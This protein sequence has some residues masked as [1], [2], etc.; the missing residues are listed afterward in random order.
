MKELLDNIQL[1]I[2]ENMY[3]DVEVQMK[4]LEPLFDKSYI[5]CRAN[6]DSIDLRELLKLSQLENQLTKRIL[7]VKPKIESSSNLNESDKTVEQIIYYSR[8]KAESL[9]NCS[10]ENDSLRSRSLDFC[11]I[12]LETSKNLG[13]AACIFNLGFYFN[14]PIKHYVVIAYVNKD[15]YLIDITY[16]QFFLLGYNFKN[17]YYEHPSYTRVCEVGGRMLDGRKD[18]AI[19][20]IENGYVKEE[21]DFINYFDAF[22]EFGDQDKLSNGCEYLKVLLSSLKGSSDKSERI[23]YSK[24]NF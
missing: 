8:K 7:K 24:M 12:V 14:L 3:E 18:T 9:Y 22:M 19:K 17:R 13:V 10:V 2:E 11:N 6:Q 4:V 15:F 23:L 16:Q 20:V 1:L 5:A 21:E